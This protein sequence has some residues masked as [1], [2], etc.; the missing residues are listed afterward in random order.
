[1]ISTLVARQ[2]FL[3]ADSID[4]VVLSVDFGQKIITPSRATRDQ[5]TISNAFGAKKVL[6][7]WAFYFAFADFEKTSVTIICVGASGRNVRLWVDEE[8]LVR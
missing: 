7:I 8:D 4:N 2:N 6:T 1:L 5:G 3:T